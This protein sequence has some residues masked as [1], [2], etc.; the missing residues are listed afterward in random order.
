[1]SDSFEKIMDEF[2]PGIYRLALSRTGDREKS[3]DIY[4]DTFLLLLEKEPV[5]RHKN[6]LRI[7]LMRTA[8]NLIKRV[9]SEKSALPLDE[10]TLTHTDTLEFELYD[11]VSSLP[12]TLRDTAVMFYIEDMSIKDISKVLGV[13]VPAVKSRLSRARKILRISFKEDDYE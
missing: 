10:I 6:Q 5:F 4:Q 1:M 13:S 11:T 2:G 3:A 12:E 9:H 8:V 7:W